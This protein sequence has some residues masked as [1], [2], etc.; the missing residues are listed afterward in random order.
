[1]RPPRKSC[2]YLEQTIQE[3]HKNV[4]ITDIKRSR[5]ERRKCIGDKV[6]NRNTQRQGRYKKVTSIQQYSTERIF[7]NFNQKNHLATTSW[8]VRMAGKL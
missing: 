6:M 1:M 2:L 3:L 7:Q 5:C 4:L 8:C